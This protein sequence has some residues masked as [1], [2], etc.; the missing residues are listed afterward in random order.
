MGFIILLDVAQEK[1]L[2]LWERQRQKTPFGIQQKQT[3]H[4]NRIGFM[5]VWRMVDLF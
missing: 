1:A 2:K 4:E 3:A 5:C